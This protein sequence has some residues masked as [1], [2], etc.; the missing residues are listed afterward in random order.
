MRTKPKS[1]LECCEAGVAVPGARFSEELSMVETE[2][3]VLEAVLG[4]SSNEEDLLESSK[5][6][7]MGSLKTAASLIVWTE[8]KAPVEVFGRK[9]SFT[10][11]DDFFIEPTE[12]VGEKRDVSTFNLDFLRCGSAAP[13]SSCW[14]VGFVDSGSSCSLTGCPSD[15]SWSLSWDPV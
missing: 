4:L 8:G 6:E 12:L 9:W 3:F 14:S 7:G 2:P 5:A 11:R 10:R 15:P 13:D 1:T